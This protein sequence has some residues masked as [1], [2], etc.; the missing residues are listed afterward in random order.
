MD[1]QPYSPA[2][3]G[4]RPRRSAVSA[5]AA[6]ALIA[7]TAA[8]LLGYGLGRRGAAQMPAAAPVATAPAAPAAPAAPGQPQDA[9]VTTREVLEVDLGGGGQKPLSPISADGR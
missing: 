3:E 9:V 7:G 8:G 1:N 6:A 5:V 2:P 4:S